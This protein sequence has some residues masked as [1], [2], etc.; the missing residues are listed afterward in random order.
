MVAVRQIWEPAEMNYA[1]ARRNMVENQVRTNRVTDPRVIRA[2]S[3]IPRDA[4]VPKRLNGVAYVDEDIDLGGGRYLM[5]PAVFG[6]LLQAAEIKANEVVLDVGCATGYSAA[7]LACLASTVIAL[8][9][10]AELAIRAGALLA[11]LG[12]DN[13][14][15]VTG[16][17]AHGD[18][19]HGPYDVILVEGAVAQIPSALTDQLADG[20]RLLAVV[21][22][23]P[24]I[25][26]ACV[27]S[28]IGEVV[29][30]RQV[31]D[32]AIAMLPSFES[33][34]RFVF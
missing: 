14:A 33:R 2:L 15:I 16:P 7:V 18:P 5:Q 25:G 12:V 1:A 4:F 22:G 32:A 29:S 23:A 17:L 28:R 34:P 24:G 6:R 27:V 21:G 10:E 19:A 13:V 20:G 8:E 31:F 30:G 9:S 3:E 11:K 26:R